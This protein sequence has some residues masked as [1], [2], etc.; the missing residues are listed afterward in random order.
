MTA[1]LTTARRQ[2]RWLM[3]K[4]LVIFVL[5][6]AIGGLYALNALTRRDDGTSVLHVSKPVSIE[7]DT[8]GPEEVAI[9]HRVQAPG[10]VEAY[11]EVEISSELVSKIVEMPVESGSTVIAGDLLCR[12]DDAEFRAQVLSAEANVAKL[13]ALVRQAEAD[14][15]KADRNL[16]RQIHLREQGSTS[17][18]EL[19]DHRTVFIGAEATLETRRQ[20]LIEAQAML[21]YAREDLAKTVI[22]APISGTVAELFAKEGEVVVT[23]T[24]NNPGTRIMVISDLSKMVV[25]CRIDEGDAALVKPDQ[26]ARVFLQSDTRRSIPGKVTRVAT[27]GTKAVGRDVV[28]F[29]ALVLITELDAAVMPGMTANVEIEVNRQPHALTVPVEAVVY[30][31]RQDLPEERVLAY[32]ERLAAEGRE[33][34]MLAQYLKLVFCAVDGKARA[35]L[36]ETGISDTQ[37]VEITNGLTGADLIIRGPYRSLDQLTDGAEIKIKE[38]KATATAEEETSATPAEPDAAP[39]DSN[40]ATVS[41]EILQA[42]AE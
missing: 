2:E 18:V 11:R 4:L 16:R 12:L 19:D 37:R 1:G 27:K 26:P 35:R 34:Q 20:E 38:K 8:V 28:T 33:T 32:D 29:E 3:K 6:G 13:R 30:R 22:S 41:E 42:N 14:Y 31:K 40:G 21:E 5:V 9:V 17:S 39:A 15:E 7:V 25:R 36:V 24:M 23:G 10:E